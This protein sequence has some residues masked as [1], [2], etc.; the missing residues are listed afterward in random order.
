MGRVGAIVGP[1]LGGLLMAAKLPM[2]MNF[3]AFAI[4]G[5]IAVLA[6]LVFIIASRQQSA[7]PEL[8][9]A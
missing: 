1:M 5:V 4:P 8:A 2:A 6:T 3:V 7:Q 9:V